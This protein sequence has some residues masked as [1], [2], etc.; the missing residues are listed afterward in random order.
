IVSV[1]KQT[2]DIVVNVVLEPGGEISGEVRS[3][4]GYLVAGAEVSFRGPGLGASMTKPGEFATHGHPSQ[5]KTQTRS[6]GTFQ[7]RMVP[8]AERV[9][10]AHPDGWANVELSTLPGTPIWLQ[11]WSRIEGV[12]RVGGRVWPKLKVNASTRNK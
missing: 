2:N 6:D 12:V 4:N 8:N 3:A 11:P 9:A 1:K 10:V 7:L 5:T